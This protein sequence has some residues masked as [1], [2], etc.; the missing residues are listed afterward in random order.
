M[1]LRTDSLAGTESTT[2][3]R[4]VLGGIGFGFAAFLAEVAAI[5]TV[6]VATG[7]AYHI[8]VYNNP[9]LIE[10]YLAVGGLAALSYTLPFVYREE[11]SIHSYLEG[12]RD[13]G[14]T[15]IVWNTAF[16]TLA[17]IGFLTK[18]TD[19]VSR[20]SLV[21]FYAGGLVALT[22][23]AAV[24]RSVLV[25]LIESG[26][27]ASRRIMLV[28]PEDEIRRVQAEFQ[29]NPTGVRV[30]SAQVLP[31]A[32]AGDEAEPLPDLL[33]SALH[34]AVDKARALGVDDVVLLVE[35]SREDVIHRIIEAFT[36]TPVAI[37][38]GAS[39][40]LGRF[41]DARVSRLAAVTA[42]SLTAPPLGPLQSF[43]KRSFD[44]VTAS[45]ALVLMAP[46]FAAIAVAIR[47][48]SPG[49]VF[50]RQRRRG[51]NSREFRIW[52]FRTMSTLDDGPEIVQAREGDH[53]VTSVG[54]YLRRF[55]LDELPQLINVVRGEMSLVGPRPHAVAHDRHYEDRIVS[56][57]RRLNVKPGITG[58][59]QVNGLRGCT[60]TDEKMR[61]R[62]EHDL[63]YID[64]WSILLDLYIIV[65]TVLSPKAFRNAH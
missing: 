52:K 23:L 14:R 5:L 16:L 48:N 57:P 61:A 53:R 31:Q 63:Y 4:P 12:H 58:W 1:A 42:L 2:G 59:A 3:F 24:T 37:H 39:N 62:V 36:M 49:P 28:G 32:S 35:W 38:L 9:G 19:L 15:F 56:Y 13:F 8:A 6:S 22:G 45:L 33:R 21:L 60:E 11:Y 18:S 30:V 65:L 7:C 40:L 10:S 43:T 51:Y 29:I 25:S 54:R 50:F 44:V 55:N 46:L 17:V 47:M 34:D 20:G 27:I 41:S 64:N 26:H